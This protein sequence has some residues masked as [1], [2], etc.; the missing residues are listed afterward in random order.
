MPEKSRKEELVK[1]L[2]EQLMEKLEDKDFEENAALAIQGT[3]IRVKDAPTNTLR[4]DDVVTRIG[5][6]ELEDFSLRWSNGTESWPTEYLMKAMPS[7]K[8]V[9]GKRVGTIIS[10]AKEEKKEDE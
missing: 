1:K 7:D 2:V 10:S 8:G 6:G 3:I 5:K 9:G 4:F